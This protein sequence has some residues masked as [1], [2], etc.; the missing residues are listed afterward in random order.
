MGCGCKGSKP[1][2]VKPTPKT[3]TVK[4]PGVTTVTKK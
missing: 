2:L 1:K 3:N 4:K